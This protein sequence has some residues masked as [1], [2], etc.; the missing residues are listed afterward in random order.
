MSFRKIRNEAV[1]WLEFVCNAKQ[2]DSLIDGCLLIDDI[3]WEF[4]KEFAWQEI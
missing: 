3:V 4:W 2:G 1:A